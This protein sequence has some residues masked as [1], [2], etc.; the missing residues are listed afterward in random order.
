MPSQ[1]QNF[2]FP[3]NK[4][5]ELMNVA[6]GTFLQLGW[7]P[8][9]AGVTKLVGYTPGSW[10]NYKQEI[11]IETANETLTVTST[12]IHGE[13]FDMLGKNKKHIQ[14]FITAFEKIKESAQE[15]NTVWQKAI[16]QLKQQTIV[17]AT[18]EAKQAQEIDKVMNL[19]GGSKTITYG[20]IGINVIVFILMVISGVNFF[21]PSGIEIM[22]WGAN[23]KPLTVTGDWWRLITC[24][25]VHIGIIHIAFNMYALYMVGIYLEPMLGKIKYAVAYLSTGVFASMASIIWHEAP[26]PSAGASGAIFGI[27]GVFLAL[28]FTNLIPK[29]M[30]RSLLQSIGIFVVYNLVYG[31]K[32]GVDNAAHA[33]GLLSGLVIGFV[34]YFTLKKEEAE[35][36]KN[37]VA[38]IIAV[39]TIAAAWYYLDSVKTTI[40]S[41]EREKTLSFLKGVKFKDGEK[42]IEKYNEFIEMQN[43]AI[44]P[45]GDTTISNVEMAKKLNEAGVG[46]WNKAKELVNVMKNYDVSESDKKKIMVM[47]EYVQDRKEE[48]AIINRIAAE[49]KQEDYQQLSAIREKIS[50]LVGKMNEL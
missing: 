42:F 41:K 11:L 12:M 44:A 28:L 14:E 46:E 13:G 31:M 40:S 17:A 23:Y 7:A 38:I 26:V 33:G 16:D 1:T 21:A 10:K 36:K 18:E 6:Y 4:S 5:S 37:T 22:Q 50:K 15:E 19:S 47:E 43:R 29:P 27:Y 35:N 48:I 25:F 2:S 32:S 34:Y 20:I 49:E 8:K 9:Y 24:V 3:A 30:R 39:V 45:L